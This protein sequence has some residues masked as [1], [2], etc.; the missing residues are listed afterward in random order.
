M[1]AMWTRNA[2]V[3]RGVQHLVLI[4]PAIALAVATAA[5][6][7]PADSGSGGVRHAPPQ[8]LQAAAGGQV[9]GYP[10]HVGI[11]QPVGPGGYRLTRPYPVHLGDPVTYTAW[12]ALPHGIPAQWI[13]VPP[14]SGGTITWSPLA[15]EMRNGRTGSEP[16]T[17]ALRA[18]IQIFATGPVSIVGPSFR[19]KGGRDRG[20][21][22]L[23]VTRVTV[24]GMPGATDSNADLRPARMLRAPWWE[25]VPWRWVFATALALAI[26]ALAIRWLVLRRRRLAVPGL[27]PG[28]RA[29]DPAE[30]ALAELSALRKLDLPAH[31]RFSEHAFVLTGIAR[32]FL[33]ATEGTPRPGDTTAEL[34]AH[35]QGATL[36]AEQVSRLAG[37]LRAFDQVKFARAPSSADEARRAEDVVEALARRRIEAR[38]AA[39]AAAA[40]AQAPKKRVA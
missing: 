7:N 8:S 27:A 10:V 11:V 12:V 38:A 1:R 19:L 21:Y 40:A 36:D 15:A 13:P 17:L 18:T 22:A 28:V 35:L 37:L 29:L 14:D 16:D 39:A 34:V 9:R 4:V 31:G 25:R 6:Q 32:R 24:Q 3:A 33:E 20:T 30:A 5:A 23:P 26:V 2:A